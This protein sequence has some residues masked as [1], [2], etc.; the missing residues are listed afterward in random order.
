MAKALA[1]K[2]GTK[3][4]NV[5][6]LG[7]LDTCIRGI[8]IA[9]ATARKYLKEYGRPRV[10]TG[11]IARL[12]DANLSLM[13]QRIIV[14]VRKLEHEGHRGEAEHAFRDGMESVG[15]AAAKEFVAKDN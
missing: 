15:L 5:F 11:H 6:Q 7:D 12:V 13:G 4:G 14:R 1:R 2:P 8:N 3:Q 10:L 9:V